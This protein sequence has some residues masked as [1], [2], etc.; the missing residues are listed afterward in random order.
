MVHTCSFCDPGVTHIIDPSVYPNDIYAEKYKTGRW[1][2]GNCIDLELSEKIVQVTPNSERAKE[3]IAEERA[4]DRL[5]IVK[6]CLHQASILD[7]R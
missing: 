6:I 7:F 4:E 5:H 2:Y 3:I 1:K